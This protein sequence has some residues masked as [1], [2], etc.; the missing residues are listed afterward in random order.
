[1]I[2]FWPR[3]MPVQ[4]EWESIVAARPKVWKTARDLELSSLR[5]QNIA[6]LHPLDDGSMF[7]DGRLSRND[8]YDIA[9]KSPVRKVDGRARS[10]R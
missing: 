10:N 8:A 2:D 5:S 6:M 3:R 4:A 9:F 1:M 7:V